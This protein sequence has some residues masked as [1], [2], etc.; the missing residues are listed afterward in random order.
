ML[1]C[2]YRFTCRHHFQ[3]QQKRV[4]FYCNFVRVCVCVP[5]HT[6]Q[7]KRKTLDIHYRDQ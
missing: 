2:D 7:N 3:R 4:G 5:L 6:K 1:F